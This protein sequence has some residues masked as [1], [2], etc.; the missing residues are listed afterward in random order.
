MTG[1]SA[2]FATAGSMLDLL[3][4]FIDPVRGGGFWCARA[5]VF[6]LHAQP[7]VQCWLYFLFSLTPVR[8]GTH[9]LCCAKE[10]KQRKALHTANP[11]CPST[12]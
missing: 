4:I 2:A 9:F 10:G 8:G 3:F 12:A 1:F 5:L 11:K 7:Q 6:L